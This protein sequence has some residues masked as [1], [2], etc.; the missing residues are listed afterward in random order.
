M[1]N[2]G[3]SL[4]LHLISLYLGLR[5]VRPYYYTFQV[6]VK[7]RWFGKKILDVMS[8]EFRTDLFYN[9]VILQLLVAL[10]CLAFLFSFRLMLLN[11]VV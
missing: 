3:K 9:H 2:F 4:Y 6:Y 1:V 5:K 7:E 11:L 10:W 8:N